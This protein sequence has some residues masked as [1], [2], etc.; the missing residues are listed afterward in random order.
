MMEKPIEYTGR[1]EII[2]G[3]SY[4]YV[5]REDRQKMN[6]E[7]QRLRA[8]TQELRAEIQELRALLQTKTQRIQEQDDTIRRMEA[9]NYR[10]FMN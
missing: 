9:N 6:A 1:V 7:I 4:T 5:S 3:V 8:E 10:C 2:D